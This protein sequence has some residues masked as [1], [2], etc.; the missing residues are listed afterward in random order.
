[1]RKFLF[2]VAIALALS[3]EGMAQT[4]T[5]RSVRTYALDEVVVTGTRNETDVRHL[6]Q[7]VSVVS[8][9]VIEQSMQPSLLPVLTEQV[10]GLFVTERGVMGYGVSGG[11]AG[12]IFLRGLSGGSARL[13]V[14]IDGHPQYAGIFGH[15]ISDAYQSLLADRVEVLRGPA[16]VLYG[17]NAMGGVINI[18]TRKMHEDGV[19]TDLHAG[20]G[21]YNTLE[22]ELTN[23]IRKGRFNSVVSGSYNRTDGHRADMGFEQ[24]GGY[25]K[26]GYDLTDNWNM[27][28]DVNVTHF[29][30]SYPGPVS[31]PLV[32][33]DQRI[34]RG[35][36]S[37]A[38]SNNYEKTS[39]AVSF[40]YNWG[41]HW[42]N[43][44]YTPSAGETSQDGRFNSNDN[45][46]G[47]SLY[48]STQFF[49]GNRITFGFD[50]FRY[51]GKAWT[52]YVSG[53][54][55]GTR[56]DLVDKHEDEVAGYVDFRQDIWNW[57]TL[58]AGL[59]V[60]HHSRVG[61]EWVPQAGLAFH[62]PHAIELKASATKGFRYPILREMYM[63][64]P[65]NPDLQ[66]ESMWNYEIALSQTLLDGR[67]RYGVNVF[68]IDGKNLIV[69]LP[70]PN[71]TGMLN[72]NFGTIY[73]SGVELQAAYRINKEWSVDGNYSF[74]H[75]ENPVIAA[76]EHKLYAGANFTKGRWSVSTGLQYIAGLYTAVGDNPQQENFVLWNLRGSFRICKWLNIWVR[77]ENLLAQKYE[78][79]AGYPMPRATVT[80]GF[81]INI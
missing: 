35:V 27:Y 14:L 58:N 33:G 11:A 4:D 67:F 28:A 76:P 20:Y 23:R 78:I 25:A 55:A 60:D 73:N 12:G 72:Q 54:D 81:N 52:D 79:N 29:N 3:A 16:S 63:F 31:A 44:G 59:R 74:L 2:T 7:T 64:P 71:G 38:L 66:P 15:P 18:V 17:S 69:T 53:E 57:L 50:W 26:L 30:A 32:D 24:Y 21:S 47:V 5:A 61:T 62:L 40:F 48:Q 10:P 37:F 19:R 42:I 65:Q 45:M 39:G 6:S 41:D 68:Y 43:D 1:M 75:M 77:G 70:N 34:T 56:S 80:G 9:P 49:K 13:M 22:T 46:M 36:T 8:R 51:G